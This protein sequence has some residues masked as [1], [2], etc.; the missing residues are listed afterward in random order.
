ML[1]K[2]ET[3]EI[4]GI[5]KKTRAVGFKDL[6]VGDKLT[7]SMELKDTTGARNGNYAL[8]VLVE[9]LVHHPYIAKKHQ[10]PNPTWSNSQNQ[11]INNISVF[12]LRKVY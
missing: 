6:V 3:Y 2:T 10:I 7:F 1:F 9:H 5:L 12:T 8:H 11:F 4:V